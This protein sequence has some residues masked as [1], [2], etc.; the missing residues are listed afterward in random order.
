MPAEKN[1]NAASVEVRH[2]DDGRFVHY[3]VVHGG[4]FHPISSERASDYQERVNAAA[5]EESE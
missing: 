3:G 4:A 1:E 5:A 2:S